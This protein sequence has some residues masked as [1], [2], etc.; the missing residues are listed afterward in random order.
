MRQ[1]LITRIRQDDTTQTLSHGIVY[2]G[3]KK[4]F[5][6]S[7]LEPP[8]KENKNRISCIPDGKYWVEKYNSPTFGEVFLFSNVKGRSMIEMHSGN[9]YDN[10]LGCLLPGAGFTDIDKDGY[11]D[12]HSSKKTIE[13]LMEL[14]PDKFT[15]TINWL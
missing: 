3:I 4:I 8:W 5:E 13:R 11:L 9:F 15:I 1:I 12:V 10:T 14:M 7:V 6:F 2:D